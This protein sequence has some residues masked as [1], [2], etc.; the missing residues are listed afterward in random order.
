MEWRAEEG[1]Q[2]SVDCDA[3]LTR[4]AK[5]TMW[6]EAVSCSGMFLECKEFQKNARVEIAIH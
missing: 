1:I 4:T 2:A 3:R 5:C 6:G